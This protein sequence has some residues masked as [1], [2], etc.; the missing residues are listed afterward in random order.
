[1]SSCPWSWITRWF[2][3]RHS[4]TVEFYSKIPDLKD[5]YPI[6]SAKELPLPWRTESAQRAAIWMKDY[7]RPTHGAAHKCSGIVGFTQMG[8]VVTAWH[9]FVVVTNGD[10]KTLEWK[11]TSPTM[12]NH[13]LE[14]P[15]L[16]MFAPPLFGDL[17]TSPLSENTVQSVL[18]IHTPWFY[19]VPAG[20]GLLMLPLDYTKEHRFTSAIGVLNP[21]ISRQVNPI[22]YW[23]VM[24]GETL[25][26]AGT[27]LCRMIPIRLDTTWHTIVRDATEEEVNYQ[28]FLSV[29]SNSTWQRNHR[30][31]GKI[32]DTLKGRLF[33]Q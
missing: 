26:R 5:A 9:D 24:S 6:L 10:G 18:K 29:I 33:F 16:G 27:P 13:Y 3:A 30:I 12:F 25:V 28:K 1:M 2:P 20:W 11:L 15:P 17:A 7:S 8:W 21:R 32:A 14:G 31:M 19:S 4:P 22:L 23:H